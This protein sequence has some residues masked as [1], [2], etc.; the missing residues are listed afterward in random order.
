VVA[1]VEQRMNTSP[2][3]GMSKASGIFN[4]WHGAKPDET[5]KIVM[6]E[7]REART[8]RFPAQ[9]LIS[10]RAVKAERESFN[11]LVVDAVE[12]EVRRRQRLQAYDDILR[13]RETVR[14][15]TGLQPDSSPVIRSLR[16]GTDRGRRMV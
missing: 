3:F 5:E 15:R 2:G 13:V 8:I 9:L 1:A 14:T 6:M 10:A 12:R 16:G 7:T 11:D 4:R